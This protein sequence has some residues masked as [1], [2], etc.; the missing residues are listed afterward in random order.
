MGLPLM[1]SGSSERQLQVARIVGEAM[2]R[3]LEERESFLVAQCEGDDDLLRDVRTFLE[4]SLRTRD[5]SSLG[6]E[7]GDI[8][9]T[10][11]TEVGGPRAHL[12]EARSGERIGPFRI[13]N[14]LGRGGM[15]V[16]Y[17]AEDEAL[18]R[19]AAALEAGAAR[20]SQPAPSAPPPRRPWWCCCRWA[21]RGAASS[22]SGVRG[23]RPAG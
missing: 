18:K 7:P 6:A 21:R 20:P 15:G 3:P 12:R 2:S 11:T 9:P 22:F 10:L 8:P 19:K 17:L 16:V 5:P 1:S 14:Y 4:L 23:S 13:L